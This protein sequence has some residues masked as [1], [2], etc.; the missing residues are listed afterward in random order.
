MSYS[1][2]CLQPRKPIISW[3][4]E[5]EAWPAA[6]GS[7]HP[8]TLPSWDPPLEY[9]IQL[10]GPQQEVW[11]GPKDDQRAGAPLLWDAYEERLEFFRLRMRRLQGDLIA[12]CW[13]LKGLIKDKHFS[14]AC[15]NRTGSNGFKCN[16]CWFRLCVSKKVFMMRAVKH[17]HRLPRT[18]Q[19]LHPGNIW[20]EAGWGSEQSDRATLLHCRGIGLQDLLRVTTNP[21]N[22]MNLWS[23]FLMLQAFTWTD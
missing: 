10:W 9:C 17:W 2:V 19:M 16:E 11:G 22:A 1:N 7:F 18:W 5:K 23:F 14:R 4:A 13:Y 3:A 15:S 6:Q 21:N 12:A 20:G 8:S